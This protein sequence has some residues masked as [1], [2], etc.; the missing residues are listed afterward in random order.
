MAAP[1]SRRWA[2][3]LASNPPRYPSRSGACA[4][5]PLVP[6]CAIFISAQEVLD[7]TRSCARRQ[8]G[9]EP[10][11]FWRRLAQPWCQ[12]ARFYAS[13]RLAPARM[14]R[15]WRTS[16]IY[17][18]LSSPR[19]LGVLSMDVFV[20]RARI[21]YPQLWLV[22]KNSNGLNQPIKIQNKTQLEHVPWCWWKYT[23]FW[24]N[25]KLM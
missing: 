19:S 4:H 16:V 18:E 22:E 5:I 14:P 8:H 25:A 15:R 21:Q 23:K 3:N 9:I 7:S 13:N 2:P 17:S 20:S 6:A 10:T 1:A 11:P 24:A 12:L